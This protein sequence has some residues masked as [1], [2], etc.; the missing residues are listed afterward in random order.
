MKK[1]SVLQGTWD[2]VS[3]EIAGQKMP[4]G[5]ARIVLQGDRFTASGMGAEYAGTFAVDEKKTPKTF[6]MTFL[7]GPEKGNKNL[8]IYELEKDTWRLCLDMTG[9]ARPQ[10]FASKPG[11]ALETLKRVDAA[12]L[13][14][15]SCLGRVAMYLSPAHRY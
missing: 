2:I 12:E 5:A 11:V 8:G 14:E 7:S 4:A 6:D 1:Q 9:K 10:E 15:P 3:L 13:K